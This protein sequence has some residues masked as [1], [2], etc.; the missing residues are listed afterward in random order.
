[1]KEITKPCP[2]CGKPISF[3]PS[4][5]LPRSTP[6]C[7][8]CAES[9]EIEIKRQ[10]A[11]ENWARMAL[12]MP[13]AYRSAIYGRIGVEYAPLLKWASERHKTG[14]GLIGDSGSGKSSAVAVFL[15]QRKLPFL[16]WSGTE[17]RDAAIDAA[18]SDNDREGARRRWEHGMTVPILVLDDVS[19]GRMTEAWSSRLYDLLEYRVGHGKPTFWT[20]QISLNN[21]GAKIARQNGG[22]MEQSA[23]IC[24][25]L[26]Q[27][28][29]ILQSNPSH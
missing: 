8:P 11:A 2:R 6:I 27:H 16:W 4:E 9:Q 17:A 24:R 12:R 20:S 22:D 29:L 14:A 26:S 5:H 7:D 23:A 1:M 10:A 18:S 15:L 25:R 21:L 3:E 13:P 19:Q 28:S